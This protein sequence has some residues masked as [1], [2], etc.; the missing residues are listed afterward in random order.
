[1]LAK[2]ADVDA[3][4]SEHGP[5]E[6]IARANGRDKLV[7][8]LGTEQSHDLSFQ[9]DLILRWLQYITDVLRVLEI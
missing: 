5:L 4:E 2:G 6:A 9:V 1:M 7:E 8:H 3:V